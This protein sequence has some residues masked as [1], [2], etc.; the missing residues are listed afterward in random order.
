MRIVYVFA[1]LTLLLAPSVSISQDQSV[2]VRDLHR[3]RFSFVLGGI[4]LIGVSFDTFLSSELNL[5]LSAGLGLGAGL[6][7]HPKGADPDV[8][9]SPYAGG[10][11]GFLAFPEIDLFGGSDGGLICKTNLY[12]PVGVHYI[13]MSGKFSI[14]LEAGY[15]HIFKTDDDSS[16]GIDSDIPMAGIKIRWVIPPLSLW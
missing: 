8:R 10:Y 9:W 14:A 2:N 1:L 7:Y 12:I 13:S 4:N 5:E 15:M 3:S 11:I 16:I 6:R